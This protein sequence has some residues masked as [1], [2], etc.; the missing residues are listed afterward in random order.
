MHTHTLADDIEKVLVEAG[1]PIRAKEIITRVRSVTDTT[2]SSLRGELSKMKD[3]GRVV[4]PRYGYYQLGEEHTGAQAS[5]PS[6]G[7]SVAERVQGHAKGST[8]GAP[9]APAG[10]AQAHPAVVFRVGDEVLFSVYIMAVPGQTLEVDVEPQP[11]KTPQDAPD[12]EERG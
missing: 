9:P 7:S 3:R 11:P 8:S 1:E 6:N 2:E 5:P 4:Q 10:D 12:T